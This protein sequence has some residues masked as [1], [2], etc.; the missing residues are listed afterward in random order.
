LAQADLVPTRTPWIEPSSTALAF[1]ARSLGIRSSFEREGTERRFAIAP[2]VPLLVASMAG[3]VL[4]RYADCATT[5]A[6]LALAMTAG[7]LTVVTGRRALISSLS[8]LTA[9]AALAGGWHHVR[10]SDL[11]SDDLARS[12]T[13]KA[14]PAWVRGVVRETLGLRRSAGFGSAAGSID[15]VTTRFVLDLTAISDGARWSAVSGRTS[16]VVEG[17]RSGIMAGQAVEAAGQLSLLAGPLNPGEFDYREYLRAQGIRLRLTVDDPASFWGD[18]T[19][20]GYFFSGWL[21]RTRAWSRARLVERLNPVVAPL[22]AALLLGQ[23]DG[24]D[25]E[26]NDAFARTGTTHL[27]AVSGLQLQ[28]VAGALLLV[29]RFAGVPRRP[30]YL[31]VGLGT[32]AY[33]LLVGLAPSVVRSAFMTATFCLGAMAQRVPR[34]ANT[35]ALAG[36][37]TLC[38][39]PAYLFDVGCQLSFLAIGALIWL[40]PLSWSALRHVCEMIRLRLRGP[41]SPLDALERKYEPWWRRTL[42]RTGGVIL[43]GVLASTVVWLAALP[44]VALRFHLVSPIGILLNIPLIPLTSLALLLGGLGLLLS[45]MAG[46][47][48][49]PVCWTAGWLLELSEAI[50]RWGV[51]QP[52][53]HRFVVGPAWGS[54]LVFYGLLALATV[55]ALAIQHSRATAFAAL[56]RNGIWALLAVWIV[57][58]WIVPW[59]GLQ[60]R[61][62]TAELLAVGH[63]LSVIVQTPDHHTILYDCGRLGDPTV[64]RRIIAPALWASGI[65]RIDTIFLSHAD[66]DHYDGL[67]D[68]AD[69]FR[70]GAVCTAPGFGGPANPR[71]IE[72]LDRVRQLGVPVRSIS[73]PASWENGDVRFT[74]LHPPADWK[75][76]APD[77]ARSLVLDIAAL[78][79][80][81]FLTGD[82]DQAGLDA[83]VALPPPEPPP[84]V[85]LAPHHGG[86]SANRARLYQWAKP[87]LVVVS[88]REWTRQA[89]DAL[90]PLEAQGISVARTWRDGAIRLNWSS[91]GV[92]VRGFVEEKD[93]QQ[94]DSIPGRIRTWQVPATALLRCLVGLLGFTIGALACAILAVIEIASWALIAPPRLA[95]KQTG[96]EQNAAV[97]QPPR[98]AE[99]IMIHTPEGVRLMGRWIPVAGSSATGRTVILLHGFA[100]LST[101]VEQHRAD[102][103]HD[104]G[105]NVAALDS[106]GCGQSNGYYTT[107][108]AREAGD[109]RLWLKALAERSAR[110]NP[111]E[112]FVPILWGRSMG[113]ATALRAASEDPRI[114]ALVLESPFADLSETVS[115]VLRRRRVPGSRLLARAVTY[116]AGRLAGVPIA[117]PRPIELAPRVTCP[118]LIVHGSN[119]ALVPIEDA[120]KLADAFPAHPHWLD[121][122]GAGHTDVIA[123]GGDELLAAIA[124]F[125]HDST[126]RNM[127]IPEETQRS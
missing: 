31:A 17:D 124:A 27:L 81:L 120:R 70:I 75:P 32:A 90:S 117:Y 87:R 85:L 29:F 86:K 16:V 105:W 96:S 79:H 64:G 12:L 116:R 111:G 40:V 56:T 113:C 2:L 9:C 65:N 35:L 8:M 15:R 59:D 36:L 123:T 68:L 125:L 83:L 20:P 66:Q 106:R 95:A 14:R 39:N 110:S 71:A 28:V 62:L 67:P 63:G 69:R 42:R 74:V 107:F 122:P 47:V 93:H 100:E 94:A 78:G 26:I 109:L 104:H 37:G 30:G 38:L 91:D 24:V 7:L 57:P 82:L 13:E 118:T 5:I 48:G 58:G 43:D 77:N 50:V 22:A 108:G 4:D 97:P 54:V 6:W 33:A 103:L 101:A 45:L 3:I 19:A 102:T 112:R 98:S 23:R 53:G 18:P 21:G 11:S 52:W 1:D 76:E 73:A 49:T 80:H 119:D 61:T 10:W 115:I 72:L 46:P 44:L 25:P 51:V 89:T 127:P 88:Q 60:P 41:R 84:D 34:P 55:S 121:V 126:P 99:P 92:D 114:A